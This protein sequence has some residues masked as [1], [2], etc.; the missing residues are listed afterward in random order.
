MNC[1]NVYSESRLQSTKILI[2]FTCHAP[3][4]EVKA[5]VRPA[6]LANME[7]IRRCEHCGKPISLAESDYCTHCSRNLCDRCMELGC[8]GRAPADSGIQA[9]YGQDEMLGN[10]GNCTPKVYR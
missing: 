4:I 1:S 6:V 10:K 5:P 3:D 8:C 2:F 7:T 9:D